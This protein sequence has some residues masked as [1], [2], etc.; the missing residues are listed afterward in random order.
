MTFSSSS[1][2]SSD[3]FGAVSNGYGSSFGRRGPA[4]QGQDDPIGDLL[5]P[6]YNPFAANS[7]QSQQPDEGKGIGIGQMFAALFGKGPTRS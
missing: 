1:F 7:Q 3:H 2:S 5:G 6:P 4:K